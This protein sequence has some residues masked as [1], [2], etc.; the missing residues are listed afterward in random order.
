[1]QFGINEYSYIFQRPKSALALRASALLLVFEKF[2]RA[3][4]F[5]IALEIMWFPIQ[6][7]TIDEK[8]NINVKWNNFWRK[9]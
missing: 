7:V 9:M 3:Y 2:T 8:R 4:L 1:M 5:Q 6:N